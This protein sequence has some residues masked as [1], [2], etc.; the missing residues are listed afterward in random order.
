MIH[1]HNDASKNVI[2]EFASDFE[3]G[4]CWGYNRFFRL[5]LLA[6]E[7]YLDTDKDMLVLRYQVRSPTFFQ[8]C[9]DQQVYIQHL[10]ASQQNFVSKVNDLSGRLAV[11]LSRH[12]R[13]T[14]ASSTSPPTTTM[15]QN[16]AT[17]AAAVAQTPS[18]RPTSSAANDVQSNTFEWMVAS[19]SSSSTTVKPAP[20]SANNN[21]N[22]RDK[23]TNAT[24]SS[25]TS[26]STSSASEQLSNAVT[27]TTKRDTKM[28]IAT[29]TG[30]QA[31]LTA[32]ANV[33]TAMRRHLSIA[34][35]RGEAN[36]DGDDDDDDNEE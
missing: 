13:P 20:R 4:E 3:V 27:T 34:E 14:T 18:M 6:A 24:T 1:Q 33:N 23:S 8:K 35:R 19:S 32:C 28:S 36:D 22:N 30:A 29:S 5:D 12:N 11:E 9:R 25:S 7:G 17:A 21:N 10:E 31:A 26:S 15:T 16:H 2:R